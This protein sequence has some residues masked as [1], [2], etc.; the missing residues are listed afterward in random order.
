MIGLQPLKRSS[1]RLRLVRRLPWRFFLGAQCLLT[2]ARQSVPS[3]GADA[4]CEL[5][6]STASLMCRNK[7]L[8]L[9]TFYEDALR[10]QRVM[11]VV[12]S[13]QTRISAFLTTSWRLHSQNLGESRMPKLPPSK[14]S[15][16][17][18]P[19]VHRRCSRHWIFRLLWI[20]HCRR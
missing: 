10:R 6:P 3:I 17:N 7:E 16:C 1:E 19:S 18:R 20:R 2:Q 13:N 15:R 12:P 4:P 5:V 14:C 11:R 9:R 8:H